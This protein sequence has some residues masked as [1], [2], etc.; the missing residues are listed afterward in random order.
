M[1]VVIK[2]VALFAFLLYVGSQSHTS[3]V[4]RND[5]R[6]QTRANE[7]VIQ[8]S[9]SFYKKTTS[10]LSFCKPIQNSLRYRFWRAT[11]SGVVAA[12]FK[13]IVSKHVE[14]VAKQVEL[15]KG[16]API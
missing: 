5:S 2:S 3:G 7:N 11:H 4:S 1:Q 13:S 15:T 9:P 14:P 12:F 10:K 8:Q 16:I 6:T